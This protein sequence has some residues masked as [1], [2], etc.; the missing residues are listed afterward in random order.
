MFLKRLLEIFYLFQCCRGPPLFERNWME[1][2]DL[3]FSI[4]PTRGVFGELIYALVS[5]DTHSVG[6]LTWK[7]AVSNRTVGFYLF[8]LSS[9]SAVFWHVFI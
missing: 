2:D 3:A 6:E 5:F 1:K 7:R 8:L 9:H 4:K